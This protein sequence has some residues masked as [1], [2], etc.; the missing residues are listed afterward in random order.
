MLSP[1][2]LHQAKEKTPTAQRQQMPELPANVTLEMTKSARPHR[3][4]KP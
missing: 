3:S 2:V 4:L 1:N